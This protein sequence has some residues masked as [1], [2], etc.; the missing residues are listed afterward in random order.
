M[1]PAVV[2]SALLGDTRLAWVQILCNLP[3]VFVVFLFWC[4]NQ[5][6]SCMLACMCMVGGF[7]AVGCH[8]TRFQCYL[9]N[10]QGATNS[11]FRA[12]CQCAVCAMVF[13]VVNNR[14]QRLLVSG[15]TPSLGCKLLFARRPPGHALCR[16]TPS[17]YII[18]H[19]SSGAGCWAL[20]FICARFV[21]SKTDGI[22]AWVLGQGMF[23]AVLTIQPYNS[24]TAQEPG[25]SWLCCALI[26]V[27]ICGSLPCT[28]ATW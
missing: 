26:G 22:C 27:C 13:S 17:Q 6:L 5:L 3:S 15:R 24:V 9:L 4:P 10:R 23:P 7:I 14:L 20:V 8:A 18:Y 16:Q 21:R 1:Q 12:P 25:A 2:T 19:V 11:V 28:R